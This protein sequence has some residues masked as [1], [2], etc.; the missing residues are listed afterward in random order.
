MAKKIGSIRG[1][2]IILGVIRLQKVPGDLNC[3]IPSQLWY[4][5]IPRSCRVWGLAL[6]SGFRGLG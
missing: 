2:V 3:L 6:L 1:T 5:G 4:Y